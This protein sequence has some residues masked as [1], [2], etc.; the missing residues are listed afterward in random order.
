MNDVI[1]ERRT[2]VVYVVYVVYVCMLCMLCML[3][4]LWM[5]CI[6]YMVDA[7]VSLMY[8]YECCV[9]LHVVVY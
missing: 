2:Y 1:Q 7:A 8:V 6:L 3:C 9:M 5:L 4:I